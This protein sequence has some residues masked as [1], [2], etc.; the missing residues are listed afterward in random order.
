MWEVSRPVVEAYIHNNAGPIAAVRDFA[1]TVRV[2]SR[3]GPRLPALAERALI[4]A[5]E[6]HTPTPKKPQNRW[7]W[8]AVGA[9]IG[10]LIGWVF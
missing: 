10:L 1:A 2:L 6:M 7:L 4:S 3:F 5:S 9:A 8:L